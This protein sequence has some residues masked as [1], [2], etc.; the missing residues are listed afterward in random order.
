[1]LQPFD[2]PGLEKNRPNLLLGLAVIQKAKRPG[3]LP[4]EIEEKRP[5]VNMSKDPMWIPKPP[6]LYGS[7]KLEIFQPY[8]PET[9]ASTTPPGTPPC[10]GSPSDSSGSVTMPPSLN[11]IRTHPPVSTSAA[12]A[13]TQSTIS[14]KNP[15]TTSSNKT[16]LQT[17]LKSLFGNKQ[18]DSV[19]SSDRSSTTT[20]PTASLKKGPVFSQVSQSMVDPIVQQY[21]KKS[22]VKKMVEE[23]EFDRPYDPEE[24]YD[25]AMGYGQVAPKRIETI[26]ADGPALSGFVDD[27]VAYDPEDETIFADIQSDVAKPPVST[28]TSD[29][30]SSPTTIST[31]IVT[32]APAQTSTPAGVIQNIPTGTVVVSAATLTEQQRMLEELNKQIEEQKRQLKEQEEALRQQREAVGMFMAHFS[33]S[34]SLMS[35]PQK[36]LPLSQLSVSTDKTSNLTDTVESSNVELQT[37]KLEDLPATPNLENDT[38]TVQEQDETQDNVKEND[39]YSSAGEIED[40]DVA[41]DP[42]DETL[43][44]EMQDDVFQGG[45]LKTCDSS[46]FR[47]G[48][49]SGRKGTLNSY[50]SRKQKPSPKKRSHRERD[51]HRS[52][53]RRNQQRSPSHSR[54]RRERDRHRRAERERSSH[55][56]REQSER[57]GRHRKEHTTRRHSHGRKR[58]P[59]SPRIKDSGSLS[60]KQSRGLSPQVLEK[61][62]A[63]N[64]LCNAPDSSDSVVGQLVES[65]TSSF[66][67]LPIKYEPDGH[68]SN[69]V[70]N[71]VKGFSPFSHELHHNVKLETS[72]PPQPQ[73]PKKTSVSGHDDTSNGSSTHVDK[74]PKQ[75]TL[76]MSKMESSIPLREIDPPIR[77]SPQSPDPEPQ[78]VKPNRIENSIAV[79]IEEIRDPLTN[80]S[81]ST[82]HVKVENND[83]PIGGQTTMSNMLWSS[84]GGPIS[85]V[86]DIGL[87][88]LNL[89]CPGEADKQ[90]EGGIPD[91]KHQDV[92]RQ[93]G[94]ISNQATG[95]D[96]KGTEIDY[97]RKHPGPG[98]SGPELGHRGPQID[99]REAGIGFPGPDM[100]DPGMQG[101]SPNIWGHGSHTQNLYSMQGVNPEVKGLGP[102]MRQSDTEMRRQFSFAAVTEI[103]DRAPDII[104]RGCGQKDRGENPHTGGMRSAMAGGFRD[105]SPDIRRPGPSFR[106]SGGAQ[107]QSRHDGSPALEVRDP[108]KR[109]F[110]G[111]GRDADMSRTGGVQERSLDSN[112]TTVLE[113]RVLRA[114]TDERWGLQRGQDVP[115]REPG[116]NI[117]Y[118][119][120]E[121]DISGPREQ[122][123]APQPDIW[124]ERSGHGTDRRESETMHELNRP[125]SSYMQPGQDMGSLGGS[126]TRGDGF[127]NI[128]NPDWRGPGPSVVGPD[129]R[130]PRNQDKCLVSHMRGPDWSG[131]G[132]DI[133][134]DWRGPDRRGSGSVRGGPFENE[135]RIHQPAR[136]GKHVEGQGPD[137]RGAR[138]LD[139]REPESEISVPNTED[140]RHDKGPGG[141]DFMVVQVPERS[142]PTRSNLGPGMLGPGGPAFLG[143]GLERTRLAMEGLG[144]TNR[145][146]GGTHFRGLGPERKCLA[147]EGQGPDVSGLAGPDFNRS[148][149]E[150]RGPD[151]VGLGPERRGPAMEGPVPGPDFSELGPE[152]RCLSIEG[153]GPDRRVPGVPD[154]RGLGPERRGN[155]MEGIGPD[156]R[157][158]GV[159]DFR[160]LGPER[161]GNAME[162]IGPDRR[163]SGGPDCR[164]PGPESRDLSMEGPRPDRRG[165]GGPD[166]RGPGPE[167]RGMYMEGPVPVRRRPGGQ[168]LRGPGPERRGSE[169]PDLRGPGLERGGPAMEGPG[170]DRRGSGGPDFRGPGPESRGLSMEGCGPDQRG[171]GGPDFRGPRPEKRCQAMEGAGPDRRRPGG[172]DFRGPGLERGGPAMEGPG[173]DRR[174]S[175]GPDFRGTR[176]ARGPAM[177]G[178]GPDRRGPGGP[179]FRGPDPERRGPAMEDPGLDWRGPIGPDFRGSRPERRSLSIERPGPDSRGSGCPD[180]RSPGLERRGPP[181]EAPRPNRRDPDFRG[182]VPDR[183]G[184]TMGG[185]WPVRREPEVPDFSGPGHEKRSHTM[186]SQE[187]RGP[188]GPG[189]QGPGHDR[190]DLAMDG[191]RPDRR[192]PGGPE[193][194]GP[195]CENRVP[196]LKG[197]RPDRR[198]LGDQTPDIHGADMKGP[199]VRGPGT[200]FTGM[201]PERT[202]PGIEGPGPDGRGQ[203]GPHIRGLGPESG[204]PNIEGPGP[205]RRD[206]VIEGPRPEGPGSSI[207]GLGSNRRVPGGPDMR[208]PEL[209][210]SDPNREGPGAD[211]RGPEGPHFRG[212]EPGRRPLNMEGP[213][214]DWRGPPIR[215]ARPER[216]VMEGP[217]PDRKRPRGPDFRGL[218][219]ESRGRDI[220][221]PGPGKQEPVGSGFR[222]PVPERRG[223][224]MESLGPECR[225]SGGPDFRGPGIRQKGIR[226][227]RDDWEGADLSGSE[228]RHDIE[229]Q[230]ADR[231]GRHLRGSRPIR[232][233]IRIPQPDISSLNHGDR[234]NEPD[235]RVSALDRRG[236]DTE[237][238]WS[239][240]RGPNMESVGNER[241]C[242][243]ND[244]KIHGNRGPGPI[245]EGLG[246]Q[247]QVHSRHGSCGEWRGPESRGPR[248]IQKRPT[249]PFPG[250]LRGPGDDWSGPVCR[251]PGPIEGDQDIVCPGPGRGGPGNGRREPER[252]GAGSN[253]RGRG[254]FFSVERDPDNQGQGCDRRGPNMGEPGSDMRGEHIGNDWMQP[255]SRATM[256]RGGYRGSPDLINSC[257]NRSDFEVEGLDRRG[258]RGPDS[259]YSGPVNRNSNIEGPGTDEGFSDCGGFGSERQGVDIESPRT[260]RPGFEH[261]FRRGSRRPAMRR[262]GPGKT[263][264]RGAPESSNIR[265]GHEWRDTNTEGPRSDRRHP[266]M[267]PGLDSRE[268]EPAMKDDMQGSNIRGP[269]CDSRGPDMTSS[270]HFNSPHLVDSSQGP[271]DP[272]SA[273]YNGPLGPTQSRG[274][275]SCPSFDNVQNQHA[276][277]PQRPRA[278]LLPTPTE[279]LIRF[280]NH[281]INNP[282]VPSPKRK[283]IDHPADRTWSRG[284]SVSREQELI[285]GQEKSPAGNMSTPGNEKIGDGEQK[286]EVG[287][288]TGKQDT[289][290]ET[291]TNESIDSDVKSS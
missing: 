216:T 263:D 101:I 282:D 26:K 233:G 266:D 88:A 96:V 97:V 27:G 116:P 184:P 189:F 106:G 249:M 193:F 264:I 284:R 157:V 254:P 275:N 235:F 200:D 290:V 287:N 129:M 40:S 62:T 192:G 135:V 133:R 104:G 14:D 241:E 252:G 54:R 160:G 246:E 173:T 119:S 59:S 65:N 150:R 39:N 270:P 122:F 55:R 118:E 153:A 165:P 112:A 143:P 90:I 170:T 175:G 120:C 145:G 205:D 147:I 269:G 13:A 281:M 12:V 244:W 108:S 255:D 64:V 11:Y 223:P 126:D 76:F 24:E 6:V 81:V 161:R 215:G 5:K 151:M 197:Q 285:K 178:S 141:A 68:K 236:T 67:L 84:D 98:M 33:V 166:F 154:F 131:P 278:A 224:D 179:D 222:E 227:R 198:G 80:T 20:T 93:R 261:D 262:L 289:C 245:Q 190:K 77:D 232:G 177:E 46:L 194:R 188:G 132:S 70:E 130:G 139:I 156:R 226:P 128:A 250:P 57:Q 15:T 144:P 142:G 146:P 41:Y 124:A 89:K 272:H 291:K 257:P 10:P 36:S 240:G 251:G 7:D 176:P 217:G 42:E 181:M 171:P 43:F 239:D 50:H 218:G 53:S 38:D 99:R 187:R 56:T 82:Q 136:K 158:P 35:P 201:R 207:D 185:L 87:R 60:P 75:E 228:P 253:R 9:P 25:P 8:N 163:A 94:G 271:R 71:A 69:L 274:G 248:F 51:R 78:F 196:S 172:L 183:E 210:Y 110:Q 260:G 259:R 1:M 247:V 265:H 206:P 288:K 37:V 208:R 30:P 52:P 140:L 273:T 180:F 125:E 113:S 32:P 137:R 283:K 168:D 152:T 162:G 267:G 256:R 16:P 72:E 214:S 237:E 3:S 115:M 277:K 204:Q 73:E 134:D 231:I 195:G 182:P 230:G 167:S 276:V 258:P 127:P 220:D 109:C 155:A 47:T 4:Q 149:P 17:I 66:T 28:Q 213:E 279:G 138:D 79:K 83:L 44:N 159:P 2:G 203:R 58:S 221:G 111:H 186:D 280:P 225:R 105:P 199:Y 242:S 19:V 114:V 121:Q 211:R 85:N 86:S 286:K 238:Q 209:Q 31:Q 202:G 63:L 123:K 21:G 117:K 48:H 148:W 191:L 18:T 268:F 164:G 243:G 34:D 95:K 92:L 219:C 22:K 107:R 100:R 45:S 234:W 102:D 91:L 174:G 169:G 74:P 23:N 229:G 103:E 29:S 212:P 61:S 49:S